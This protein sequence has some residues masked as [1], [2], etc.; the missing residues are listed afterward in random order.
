[1]K[2]R[3]V[4]AVVDGLDAGTMFEVGYARAL[5]IPVIA[6]VQAEQEEDLKMLDGT[7]CKIFDDFVTAVY[8]TAW[9]VLES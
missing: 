8:H 1:M 7:G 3:A 9:T 5:D 4:F 6:C 2:S